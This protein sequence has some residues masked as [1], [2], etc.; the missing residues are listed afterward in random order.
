VVTVSIV[1]PEAVWLAVTTT[2]GITAPLPSRTMPARLPPVAAKPGLQAS[3]KMLII[4][5]GRKEKCANE[6]SHA[7]KI[8]PR[9]VPP[10]EDASVIQIYISC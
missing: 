4:A 10:I 5:E 2:P 7:M 8:D 6:R 9:R 1:I 3:Q